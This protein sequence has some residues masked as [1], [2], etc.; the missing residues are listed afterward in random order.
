MKGASVFPEIRLESRPMKTR[1]GG[2][3]RPEFAIT[4]WRDFGA[5][6]LANDNPP[7]P[8]IENSPAA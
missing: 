8:A 7:P 4:G 5:G 2:K 3:M 6:E 1:F